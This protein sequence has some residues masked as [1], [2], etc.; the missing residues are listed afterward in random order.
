MLVR[1]VISYT[2][3]VNCDLMGHSCGCGRDGYGRLRRGLRLWAGRLRCR[4]TVRRGA[5]NCYEAGRE[6]VIGGALGSGCSDP[7]TPRLFVGASTWIRDTAKK[8]TGVSCPH[9]S[10]M[11]TTFVAYLIVCLETFC[12]SYVRLDL[13]LVRCARYVS[14]LQSSKDSLLV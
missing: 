4:E 8:N 10:F 5:G 11:S 3:T 9:F 13:V 6:I 12:E 7:K 14:F 1:I 2:Y